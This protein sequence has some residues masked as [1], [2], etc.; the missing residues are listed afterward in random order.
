[1]ETNFK[2]HSILRGQH[3]QDQRSWNH[4]FARIWRFESMSATE[5]WTID[6]THSTPQYR[7]SRAPSSSDLNP[8]AIECFRTL[9]ETILCETVCNSTFFSRYVHPSPCQNILVTPV[10]RQSV[11][12][13]KRHPPVTG[14]LLLTP[15]SCSRVKPDSYVNNNMVKCTFIQL[16]F[17]HS[18]AQSC[19]IKYSQIHMFFKGL[20]SRFQAFF[21]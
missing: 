1:M 19:K 13:P 9:Q 21:A 16:A 6:C 10:S 17:S 2:I 15:V 5:W 11:K 12:N 4:S 7:G 20:L 14:D 18:L 8:A 3:Q